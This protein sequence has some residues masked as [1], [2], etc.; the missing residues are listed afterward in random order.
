MKLTP[1]IP[2]CYARLLKVVGLLSLLLGQGCL[3]S[4]PV[5][6]PNGRFAAFLLSDGDQKEVLPANWLLPASPGSPFPAANRQPTKICEL[7]VADAESGRSVRLDQTNGVFC[8][9]A[10]SPD[11][12]SLLYGCFSPTRGM[13]GS[14]VEGRMEL[15]R[16]KGDG[17]IEVLYSRAL[18]A[19]RDTLGR[20]PYL[21]LA[22]APNGVQVAVPWPEPDGLLVMDLRTKS[23]VAELPG[24]Y[25]PSWSPDSR[26]LACFQRT[27]PAG[28][29]FYEWGHWE[30]GR[31]LIETVGPMQAPIW[32]GSNA[33]LVMQKPH[34]AAQS[35]FDR[36]HSPSEFRVLRVSLE[37]TPPIEI[38][39]FNLPDTESGGASK[40]R[41]SFS[42]A[43]QPDSDDLLTAFTHA[44]AGTQ[45]GKLDLETRKKEAL[46]AWPLPAGGFAMALDTLAPTWPTASDSAAGGTE[47]VEVARK[48]KSRIHWGLRIGKPEWNAPLVLF[49]VDKS[50]WRWITPNW[51]TRLRALRALTAEIESQLMF[52]PEGVSRPDFGERDSSTPNRSTAFAR[53][54]IE[55]LFGPSRGSHREFAERATAPPEQM[56]ELAHQTLELLDSYPNTELQ[57]D[58][59]TDANLPRTVAE[60]ELLAAFVTGDY[61]R[62]ESAA[63]RAYGLGQLLDPPQRRL[64]LDLIRTECRF[65]QGDRLGAE[66]ML[67]AIAVDPDFQKLASRPPVHP[68]DDAKPQWSWF[69]A[70]FPQDQQASTMKIDLKIDPVIFGY[71]RLEKKINADPSRPKTFANP[72]G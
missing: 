10:W 12:Q 45:F 36:A 23:V 66:R 16:W 28:Y 51:A 47:G 57:R 37:E 42:F 50:R 26:H 34:S 9:P 68:S 2:C 71:H 70:R 58:A 1:I 61:Q 18:T 44:D 56:I 25:L 55:S 40:R 54:A 67:Q 15:R 39:T 30:G 63:A 49:D 60:V 29:Y 11:G 3:F 69:Y 21:P 33:V 72:R 38:A 62:A 53:R 59:K 41:F 19:Q 48:P 32:D 4:A 14:A 17:T 13:D 22:W 27:Q 20:M 35:M 52:D 64:T 65:L 7:W 43:R 46:A 5:W 31:Q 24:I 8:L 6:S